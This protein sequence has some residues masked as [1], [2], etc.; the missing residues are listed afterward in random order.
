MPSPLYLAET[1]VNAWQWPSPPLLLASRDGLINQTYVVHIDCCPV[2]VLQCLNTR[3]FTPAVH[4]DIEAVTSHLERASLPTPRLL[5]TRAGELWHTVQQPLPEP[6]QIWRCM[7][8]EGDRTIHRVESL[9]DALSAACLVARFHRCLGSLQHTFHS[10]RRGPNGGDL[11]DTEAHIKRMQNTVESHRTHR[12][13]TSVAELARGIV[14]AWY[15][16]HS[17]PLQ[18][19]KRVIHG[20]L[21]ISNVR[22][23]GN[24][25]HCLIDLDTMARGTL[26]VELGDAMRS[27][28]N[29]GSE[30][31]PNP[32]FDLEVFQAA[33]TGYARGWKDSD[34]Q[35]D[36]APTP[37]EWFSIIDGTERITLELASRFACDALEETYFGFDP[38]WGTRGEHNLVRARGQLAL[39]RSI[40]EQRSDA[41]SIV[42]AF[43]ES[44]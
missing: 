15:R 38:R 35:H 6:P 36:A 12:L 31:E 23:L 16:R 25:A 17:S 13:W 14:D 9:H 34:S 40:Y 27:W 24:E 30:N 11:H 39:A 19:P 28:C 41:R 37:D 42:Q 33:M 3:V 8:F 1:A 44:R 18:L 32:V 20:D 26:D 4:V 10:V 22:F 2:A 29:R 7:R 5:R 21:K 43:C